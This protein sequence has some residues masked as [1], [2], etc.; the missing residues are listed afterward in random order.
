M[1]ENDY[2]WYLLQTYNV[3]RTRILFK[4]EK[5]KMAKLKNILQRENLWNNVKEVF[6]PIVEA[7]DAYGKSYETNL[8]PGHVYINMIYTKKIGELIR[9]SKT[10]IL[11]GKFA[12]PTIIDEDSINRFKKNIDNKKNALN[13][14][15]VGE[16]VIIIR[17][18]LHGFDGIIKEINNN[19]YSVAIEIF[20]CTSTYKLLEDEIKKIPFK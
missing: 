16:N 8:A 19:V 20:G 2:K 9:V 18:D 1:L 14:F 10:F 4:D 12:S 11:M 6:F 3:V 5:T 7:L 17:E 15:Y 13:S